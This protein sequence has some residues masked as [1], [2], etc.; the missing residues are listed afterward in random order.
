MLGLCR[1]GEKG[2][3]DSGLGHWRCRSTGY[4]SYC[5]CRGHM[6]HPWPWSHVRWH[7]RGYTRH[8]WHH[9]RHHSTHWHHAWWHSMHGRRH[10][11]HHGRNAW[12]N[13]RHSLISSRVHPRCTSHWRHPKLCHWSSV[14][15]L[16]LDSSNLLCRGS[17][18]IIIVVLLIR[19]V[20]VV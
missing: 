12:H 8:P 6:G 13:R 10:A 16:G 4:R 20:L 19:V 14:T 18:F 1:T 17:C 5:R 9:G 7:S 3:G 11:V 2:F 15:W